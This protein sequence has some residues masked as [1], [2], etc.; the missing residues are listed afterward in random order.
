MLANHEEKLQVATEIAI[1]AEVLMRCPRHYH[2]ILH[3]SEGIDSALKLK[4]SRFT[5]CELSDFFDSRRDM[6]DCIEEVFERNSPLDP[7]PECEHVRRG[8]T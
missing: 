6:T 1:E 8:T 3:G 4:S 5:E 2:C 7:C